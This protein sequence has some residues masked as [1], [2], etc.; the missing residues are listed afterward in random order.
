MAGERAVLI[1]DGECPMCAGAAAWIQRRALPGTFEFL[2]CQSP[3]RARR[4]PELAEATCL[5]AMQLVLP[6]GGILSGDLAIPKILAR[7]RGWWWL[8][9]AFRLPGVGRVAPQVYR[10]V[11][12]HRHVISHAIVPASRPEGGAQGPPG[13]SSSS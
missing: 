6:E 2:A 3:E 4:F 10:W 9:A 12:R 8:A 11:A 7:L 5:E 1:Y 13:A